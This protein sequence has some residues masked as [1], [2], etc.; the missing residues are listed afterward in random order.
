MIGKP[1]LDSPHYVDEHAEAD[2]QTRMSYGLRYQEQYQASLGRMLV[3]FNEVESLVDEVLKVAL[4]KL[5]KAHLYR[6]DD[7]FRQKV[8]RLELAL[9]AFPTWTAPDFER[10]RR[11]NSLRNEL[12]HGHFYQDSN[13]G[14]W[15]TRGV[16]RKGQ[17]AETI[18]PEVIHEWTDEV[19]QAYA[20]VGRLL[21]WV[22]FGNPPADQPGG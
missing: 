4:E 20:D 19:W 15:K 3:K 6:V 14:D 21:P 5:D 11:I 12:A 16:H 1:T 9:C 7:Y 10:L 8:D 13:S 18:T 22:W 17:N 2:R